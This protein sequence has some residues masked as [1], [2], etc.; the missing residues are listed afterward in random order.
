MKFFCIPE[1]LC[2]FFSNHKNFIEIVSKWLPWLLV[3]GIPLGAGAQNAVLAIGTLCLLWAN[4]LQLGKQYRSHVYIAAAGFLWLAIATLLNPQNPGKHLISYLLGY[5]PFILLPNLLPAVIRK[6]PAR[7]PFAAGVVLSALAVIGLTQYVWG[8]QRV[9][10]SLISGEHRARGTWT[11]PLTFA[12]AALLVLPFVTGAWLQNIKSPWTSLF[13][14]SEC[15]ILWT[16]KSRVVI[17]VSLLLLGLQFFFVAQRRVRFFM[18]SAMLAIISIVAVT[19]NDLSVH[20]KQTLAGKIDR[21]TTEYPDDRVA[22]WHAHWHLSKQRPL[23]GHGVHISHEIRDQAYHDIGL[24]KFPKKYAAHNQYLQFL[25]EGGI[26]SVVWMMALFAYWL[27]LC[28]QNRVLPL[29]QWLSFALVGFMSAILTQNA[30]QDNEV[31]YVLT[32]LLSYCLIAFSHD[33]TNREL[34]SEH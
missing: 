12:Y 21:H 33:G 29:A 11:H 18:L 17:V 25:T 19:Q 1:R 23:V 9:D 32:L 15:I 34:S 27:H 13:F 3:A 4:N 10:L 14:A 31:R 8:W 28:W 6:L 26:A 5:T 16:S 2:V 30:F 22:F 7:V 24:A 20:F